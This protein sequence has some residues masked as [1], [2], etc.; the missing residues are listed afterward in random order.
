VLEDRE[1]EA[2][3]DLADGHAAALAVPEFDAAHCVRD[4]EIGSIGCV[5]GGGKDRLLLVSRCVVDGLAILPVWS[6]EME[7]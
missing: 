7:G 4:G 1:H 2:G 6:G 3:R 5:F